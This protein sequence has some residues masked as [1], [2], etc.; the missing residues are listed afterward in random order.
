MYV[1]PIHVNTSQRG[2][3]ISQWVQQVIGSPFSL[4]GTVCVCGYTNIVCLSGLFIA[5]ATL[6]LLAFMTLERESMQEAT[7]M[8]YRAWVSIVPRT[9]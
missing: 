2:S 7:A 9:S 4:P 8:N 3:D 5:L 1:Y 6:L